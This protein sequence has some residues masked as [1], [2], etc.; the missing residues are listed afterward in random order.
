MLKVLAAL[1][2]S[3]SILVSSASCSKSIKSASGSGEDT[4]TVLTF[5]GKITDGAKGVPG[6]VVTDGKNFAQTGSDGSYS[7]PYRQAAT[8]IYIS[9][10]AGYEVPVSNSVPLYWKAIKAVADRRQVDFLLQ[11]MAASDSKHYMIAVGD[12][13]VRNN[14]ELA[15]LKP[16]LA[17]MKNTIKARNMS[18]VHIMV[19]GDVV[20]DTYNM[21]DGS[22][23][24]FSVL[25]LPVYY[26]IGNH[27]HM[28]TT[29]ESVANDQTSDSNYIR[30]YGPT[31][32]SFNRGSVH[33]IVLDNIRYEGG[34]DTKYDVYFSQEQLDWV[35]KDLS[36]VPKTKALV[37]MFHAPSMTRFSA[38]YGNSA[39]LHKLLSG[40][41]AVQL[42]SGHTHYN[43]VYATSAGMIEHNVGAVCG[44]FWE[45]PVCLDGTNLGYKIFEIDGAHFKWE[46]HDYLDATAQFSVFR[47][48]S[49][50]APLLP[51]AQELLVN[52]WDWEPAWQVL[53]SEDNGVTF[54]S[55]SRY[56]EQNRVYDVTAYEY[57]GAKGENKI[58][59]RSWI[60]ANTTDHVFTVMPAVGTQKVII[61]VVS[62]FKTYTKEVSL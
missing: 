58:P 8:H 27:D 53:Y 50:R 34:P 44:G 28:K 32:Y 61:K 10:P 20:F 54:K 48:V 23:K 49:F 51:S 26:A 4:T 14:A 46:Y 25:E 11:K 24:E 18:P 29:V 33:Y 39:D 36:Y 60:G 6:V 40:Y 21:H 1:L 13:Q 55:M 16:I 59:G 2:C 3:V 35:K 22:K 43:S 37:V 5:A 9:S 56:D 15:K 52:V 41:A 19:A 42:I 57:F 38:T 62:R 47:P 30:H 12:P 45:G 7:L 31:Y 17:E